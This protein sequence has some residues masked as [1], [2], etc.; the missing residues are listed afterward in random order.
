MP[1]KVT[2]T[3]Q[4]CGKTIERWPYEV[5][6]HK[7]LYCSRRCM[8]ADR[9]GSWTGD[10][11][12]NWIGG[13]QEEKV[14]LHCGKKHLS[15]RD[16][17][18]YCSKECVDNARKQRA[19]FVCIVCGKE[20]ELYP[21]QVR[22]RFDPKFCSQA[23]HGVWNSEHKSGENSPH[24]RGGIHSRPSSSPERRSEYYHQRRARELHCQVNDLTKEQWE[25]ILKDFN[26]CCA[27]CLKPL[28]RADREHVMPVS[29]GGNN[30]MSNVVPACRRCNVRKNKRTL[31]EFVASAS[32]PHTLFQ[33]S[34]T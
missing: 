2:C 19:R 24:W 11:N 32:Y 22:Q 9:K 23:C 10:K 25:Q 4:Y 30:T 8:Y 16:N 6:Q 7:S 34:V 5:R 14:C 31:I 15:R 17:A 20:F 26:Y 29:R 1:N 3:C 12:P 18:G 13:Y 28:K 21:A 27:Y 33:G